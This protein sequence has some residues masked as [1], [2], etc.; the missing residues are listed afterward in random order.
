MMSQQ[1]PEGWLRL[2]HAPSRSDL[3]DLGLVMA[4]VGV[5]HRLAFDGHQWGLWV[6]PEAA[7]S[8]EAELKAYRQENRPAPPPP[9]VLE[10]VDSGWFGVLGYLAV[11]WLLPTLETQRVF[12]WDWQ[13]AGVMAAGM[14]LDGDWW[15]TI[16]AL[17][18]HADI[19]HILANSLFGGVFG[20]FAGRYLGSG[21][22]WLLIL[23]SG[24]LGNAVNALVQP[25]GF[26]SIGAS[27]ATFAALGLVG[28][29]VW[30]CGYFRRGGNWRRNFAP[31]FAGIAMLAYTG[32]G[33]DNTDIL[34]HV[35]G[36]AAGVFCGVIA[37]SFRPARLGPAGQGLAGA[38]ALLVLGVA[39]YLAGTAV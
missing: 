11:I 14:V 31:I 12:G 28:A 13:E 1:I 8:A 36:F 9:V 19:A 15:R 35:F 34:A 27:T 24:A 5:D 38:T 17:T 21:L 20:L 18:L 37:A 7:A 33:G 25:D 23:L 32:M 6:P 39:W 3:A 30:R 4:A 2:R 26:R 16:T 29:F 22:G 10:T